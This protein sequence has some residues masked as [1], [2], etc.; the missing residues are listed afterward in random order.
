MNKKLKWKI[1]FLEVLGQKRGCALYIEAHFES[2]WHMVSSQSMLAL[3]ITICQL[4]EQFCKRALIIHSLWRRKLESSETKVLREHE[5]S[6]CVIIT[7][8]DFWFLWLQNPGF[9]L[10]V[11]S[12]QTLLRGPVGQK[13]NVR[14]SSV[15]D[16]G[17]RCESSIN[18]REKGFCF[19]YLNL[20]FA[21]LCE[22][23]FF[24]SFLISTLQLRAIIIT[25]R[26]WECSH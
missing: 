8:I 25:V 22:L 9:F 12:F 20:S 7:G 15:W 21:L 16:S 5:H 13:M 6:V 17:G 19:T 24:V 18:P 10:P 3:I 1:F 2:S 14:V 11:G 4:W 26:F 23:C